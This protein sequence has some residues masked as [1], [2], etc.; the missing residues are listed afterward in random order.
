MKYKF[1]LSNLRAEDEIGPED[2]IVNITAD[3]FEYYNFYLQDAEDYNDDQLY[4]FCTLISTDDLSITA[5]YL[6]ETENHLTAEDLEENSA[7]NDLL[8][9]LN[10]SV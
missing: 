3:K 5:E 8:D 1:M 7:L 2:Q 10:I 4:N 9:K 6:A